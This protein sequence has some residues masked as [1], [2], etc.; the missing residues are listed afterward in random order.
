VGQETE[1]NCSGVSSLIFIQ[2]KVR[3]KALDNLLNCELFLIEGEARWLRFTRAGCVK[4]N[5]LS[6][7]RLV[8]LHHVRAFPPPPASP[9]DRAAIRK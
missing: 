2:T 3:Q 1:D 6:S 7:G 4:L 5:S 8:Y 9:Q